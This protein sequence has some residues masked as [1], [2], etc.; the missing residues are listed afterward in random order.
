MPNIEMLQDINGRWSVTLPGL[1]LA[2]LSRED[3]EAF[4]ATYR[5]LKD[6]ADD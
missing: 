6:P 4:V 5:R 1:V 3:A 2:D